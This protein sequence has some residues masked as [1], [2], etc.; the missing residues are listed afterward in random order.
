[1]TLQSPRNLEGGY[2]AKRQEAVRD[3]SFERTL[4]FGPSDIDMDPLMVAGHVGELVDLILRHF[5]RLA[6]GAEFL[7]DLRF[8]LFEPSNRMVPISTSR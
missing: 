3:R 6:L 5:D 2:E 4:A 1:M 8:Q 7:A